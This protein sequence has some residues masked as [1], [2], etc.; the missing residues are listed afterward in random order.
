MALL[1]N[2]VRGSYSSGNPSKAAYNYPRPWRM[3]DYSEV[4]DTGVVDEFGYPTYKSDVV[5]APQLHASAA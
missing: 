2:T 5:V 3:N 4:I 1:V